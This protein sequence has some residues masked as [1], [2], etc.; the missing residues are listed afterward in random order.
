VLVLRAGASHTTGLNLATISRVL[1]EKLYV[2]VVDVLDVL[3][4]ELAVLATRLALIILLLLSHVVCLSLGA[5]A[6]D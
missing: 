1:A 2:L 6:P 4:A 3:L 5:R